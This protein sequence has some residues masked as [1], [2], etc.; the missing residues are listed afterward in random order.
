[1]LAT[2]LPLAVFLQEVEALL[3]EN[4]MLQG[5]LHSQEDD[6]RLQNSTLMQELSKVLELDPQVNPPPLHTTNP[7]HSLPGETPLNRLQMHIL[8]NPPPSPPTH[9]VDVLEYSFLL[10]ILFVNLLMNSC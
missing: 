4:E 6:F 9:T 3:S 8:L 5:K 10:H 2:E 7:S 1:M